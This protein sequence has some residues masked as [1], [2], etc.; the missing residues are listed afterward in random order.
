VLFFGCGAAQPRCPAC[1]KCEVG[2]T[3][4]RQASARI[5][6]AGKASLKFI[7]QTRRFRCRTRDAF[8]R[9]LGS[10]PAV[11]DRKAR[12]TM[13]LCE[14]VAWS[15]MLSVDCLKRLLIG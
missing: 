1:F 10:V 4:A 15:V 3:A 8:G 14:I 13:R 6:M 11:A 12:E 5:A 7:C 2:Y 9:S